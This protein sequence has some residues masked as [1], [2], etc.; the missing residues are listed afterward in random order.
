MTTD[1]GPVPGFTAGK[2]R[3]QLR[4]VH[5]RITVEGMSVSHATR[6]LIEARSL[7]ART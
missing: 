5:D 2:Y 4:A 3:E 1:F 6:V 7:G